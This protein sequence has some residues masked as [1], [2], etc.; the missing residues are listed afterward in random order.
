[1]GY[2]WEFFPFPVSLSDNGLAEPAFRQIL[3][4]V[5]SFFVSARRLSGDRAVAGRLSGA[6]IKSGRRACKRVR[7]DVLIACHELLSAIG[8]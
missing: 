2:T 4:T 6:G 5:F 8:H 7:R 1:M 3:V